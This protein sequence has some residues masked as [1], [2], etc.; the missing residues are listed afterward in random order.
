LLQLLAPLAPRYHDDAASG[1]TLLLLD[2]Y[3]RS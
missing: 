3:V 2:L 1:P